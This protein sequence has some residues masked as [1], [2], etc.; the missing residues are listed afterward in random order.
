MMQTLGLLGIR[1]TGAAFSDEFRDV[2]S[3]PKGY[4]ELPIDE[5]ANGIH[6]GRY[7]GMA[8]KLF[9][10]QLLQTDSGL[11]RKVVVCQRDRDTVLKS[12]YEW[13]R[14]DNHLGI[15]NT[16]DVA[17]L[18]YDLNY[19]CIEYFLETREPDYIDVWYENMVLDTVRC[20]RTIADF[21]ECDDESRIRQAI[22]NVE[23]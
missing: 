16:E 3:N 21:I 7:S 18:V 6:D 1:K 4:W 10:H 20:V 2:G 15:P 11:I 12:T 8:I 14:R 22:E 23:V 9:G 19:R 13:L 5:T 17:G